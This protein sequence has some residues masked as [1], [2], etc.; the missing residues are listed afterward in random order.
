LGEEL[1]GRPRLAGQCRADSDT[2]TAGLLRDA[3][4]M[5]A[6]RPPQTQ[7]PFLSLPPEVIIV[8]VVT[9]APN[10]VAILSRCCHRLYD[11]IY[12]P[13]SAYI[14]RT[15]YLA[16]FDDPTDLVKAGLNADSQFDWRHE[17]QR[18][19]AAENLLADEEVANAASLTATDGAIDTIL[20]VIHTF[21]PALP[22][23][24]APSKNVEWFANAASQPGF[25]SLLRHQKIGEP[26]Q[27]ALAPF[28]YV[29]ADIG[30]KDQ[31]QRSKGNGLRLRTSSRAFVYDLRNYTEPS[32]WGP[33]RP[34]RSGEVSWVHIE[35]IMLVMIMNCEQYLPAETWPQLGFPP[36]TLESV[37]PL[38]APGLESRAPLD[39]AGVAGKW[40]RV[41]CF[42][43]YPDLMGG[44]ETAFS[45]AT[46]DS[47]DL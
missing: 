43:D 26:G 44:S 30:L 25:T 32:R 10:D 12:S 46:S 28:L 27:A 45:P 9:C 37:R 39:W 21:R 35:N 42:M 7:S 31:D 38:S 47:Y 19:V 11:L 1:F 41:V 29:L 3:L 16:I 18:R 24:S 8:I 13:T 5:L 6:T 15:L 14:W 17:L 22:D 40:T 33:F 36:M 34:D 23:P 2:F 4:G 20:N